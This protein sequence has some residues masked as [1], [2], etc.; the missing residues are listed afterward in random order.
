VLEGE[1][2]GYSYQSAQFLDPNVGDG[3]TVNV[4]GIA[5]T[6]ADA[7]NYVVAEPNVTTVA[8]ITGARPSAFGVS[9]GV[10]AYQDFVIGPTP[11]ETPYGAAPAD[12]VGS[13]VGNQKKRHHPIESNRSRVD[14]VSGLSLQVIEGGV[15]LPVRAMP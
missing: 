5:L 14:F 6:G 3:K 1:T 10:L 7:M 11:I 4:S 15:Q 2:V 13:Y 12:T 9:D 8:N